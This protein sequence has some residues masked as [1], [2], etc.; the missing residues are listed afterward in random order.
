MI[1]IESDT[2]D[3]AYR[4]AS[5]KLGCSITEIEF[6]IIQN[7]SKGFLGIGKKKAIIYAVRKGI[8]LVELEVE[9][10][11]N[12]HKEEKRYRNFTQNNQEIIKEIRE[13]ITT[14]FKKSCFKV[15][16]KEIKFIDEKSI[17][18]K[19]DGEDAPL[20]I[21]KEGYRYK[22]LSFLLYNI[23]KTKYNKSLKLEV[24]QF[25]EKQEEYIDKQLI[26][27]KERVRKYGRA[28]TKA[29]D[30]IL[31]KLALE[32]LRKEF[33]DKYV[34]IKTNREGERYIVINSFNSPKKDDV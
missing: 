11:R 1:K 8:N 9:K 27:V 17:Y 12:S 16:V 15:E 20:L 24:A 14:L 26:Q 25:L 10:E 22:A 23:L 18:L 5:L 34:G 28:N 31:L 3:E 7:P 13:S 29:L 6:D 21:G 19:I 2:L 33:S 4:E 32:N 30:G